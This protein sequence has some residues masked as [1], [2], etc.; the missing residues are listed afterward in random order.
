M[1]APLAHSY[2]SVGWFDSNAA[3]GNST[4]FWYEHFVRDKI[5]VSRVCYITFSKKVAIVMH[6]AP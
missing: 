1:A 3:N 5:A 2:F 4:R 6:V